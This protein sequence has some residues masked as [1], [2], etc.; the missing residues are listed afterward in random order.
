MWL[1]GE[2]IH[3]GYALTRTGIRAGREHWL[4][5]IRK[6]TR[7]RSGTQPVEVELRPVLSGR[8]NEEL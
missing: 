5:V 3:G 4:L 1:E 8:T 2:R 7:S 6:D